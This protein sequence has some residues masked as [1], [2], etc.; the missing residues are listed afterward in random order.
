MNILLNKKN[1]NPIFSIALIE[2]NSYIIFNRQDSF[3]SKNRQKKIIDIIK[4]IEI[5]LNYYHFI[6]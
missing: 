4:K 1:I 3:L 5:S 6:N 2:D